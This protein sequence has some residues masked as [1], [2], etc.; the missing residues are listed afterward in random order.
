MAEIKNNTDISIAP[1]KKKD[2]SVRGMYLR[3]H[4]G[5]TCTFLGKIKRCSE[6][7]ENRN[8]KATLISPLYINFDNEWTFLDHVWIRLPEEVSEQKEY[9]LLFDG[10]VYEY[11]HTSGR[12]GFGVEFLK[13][14]TCETCTEMY[15]HGLRMQV[16]ECHTKSKSKRRKIN[17][18]LAIIAAYESGADLDPAHSYKGKKKELEKR[19]IQVEKICKR[20]Y[21]VGNEQQLSPII[22]QKDKENKIFNGFKKLHEKL[23]KLFAPLKRFA[24]K[25]ASF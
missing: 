16:A 24:T 10:L 2:K 6:V 7:K 8:E 21:F 11:S 23:V 5:E 19:K 15:Y 13:M 3:E 14:R 1:R 4:V 25:I 9:V 17:N 12:E 22:I 18:N 20:E